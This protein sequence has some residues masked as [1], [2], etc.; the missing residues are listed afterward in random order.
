MILSVSAK[1]VLAAKLGWTHGADKRLDLVDAR[2]N[3]TCMRTELGLFCKTAATLN[4]LK[5]PF[6]G[7]CSTKVDF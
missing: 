5:R 4:A 3:T 1:R 6:F 7:V 2:V